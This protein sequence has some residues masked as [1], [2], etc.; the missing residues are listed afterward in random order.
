M[1][2]KSKLKLSAL[3]LSVGMACSVQAAYNPQFSNVYSFGDSLSDMGAMKGTT[4]TIPG[5]EDK[6][7]ITI[8]NIF[9]TPNGQTAAGHIANN[10]GK[11]STAA[12]KVKV[13]NNQILAIALGAMNT[14]TAKG[15]HDFISDGMS[16]SVLSEKAKGEVQSI[17]DQLQAINKLPTSDENTKASNALISEAQRIILGA[18]ITKGGI[19]KYT[20]T[21]GNNFAVGGASSTSVD[22][23]TTFPLEQE[24]EI[25]GTKMMVKA[26]V[27]LM[28]PSLKDQVDRYL[29]RDGKADPNAL[30]T[31]TAGAN[32]LFRAST[33]TELAKAG[34]YNK[35]A[36]KVGSDAFI[37]KNAELKKLVQEKGLALTDKEIFDQATAAGKAAAEQYVTNLVTSVITGSAQEVANQTKR[38]MDAGAKY[39][40]VTNMPDVTDTPDYANKTAAEKAQAKQAVDGF[41][42]MLQASLGQ[43]GVIYTDINGF[44]KTVKANP[45]RY[46]FDTSRT[47]QTFCSGSSLLCQANLTE[48]TR[49][50]ADMT[51]KVKTQQGD[52]AQ[53]QSKAIA[54]AGIK[55]K[56]DGTV[57]G[58]L[59][60]AQ[61]DALKKAGV[62]TEVTLNTKL[63]DAQALALQE[64]SKNYIFADGVHPSSAVHKYLS[65]VVSNG[66][67]KAPGYHASLQSL[68][69]SGQNELAELFEG[70]RSALAANPL[71]KGE[72]RPYVNVSGSK[73]D[74][75]EHRNLAKGNV[76]SM[77]MYAAMDY[78]ISEKTGGGLMLTV[79]RDKQDFK[80]DMAGKQEREA[81]VA[82]AYINQKIT[83][84][85]SW[86]FN[87]YIGK[88]SYEQMR[89]YQLG[90]GVNTNNIVYAE[91]TGDTDSIMAGGS[92]GANGTYTVSGIDLAPRANLNYQFERIRGYAETT[93][94]A[95][96]V[97]YD[98]TDLKR[99]ELALGINISKAF[100]VSGMTMKPYADLDWRQQLGGDKDQVVNWKP[101]ASANGYIKETIAETDR[102]FGTVK[103][104][105]QLVIT[106]GLTTQLSYSKKFGSSLS[107][108]DRIMLDVGYQF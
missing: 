50:G 22:N 61:A 37:A 36:E 63:T 24:I 72:L 106:E 53:T 1:S 35:Q 23:G 30:Y 2:Y 74:G 58:K 99:S 101:T 26:N 91:T 47:S 32:D 3:A 20:D 40:V 48:L 42:Q 27:P 77:R 52:Q 51:V 9:T 31:I 10:Y 15:I 25:F 102:N 95:G 85:W 12:L 98:Q 39:V 49:A 33:V 59:T 87:G 64:A 81:Y 90:D 18:Y 19:I 67:L 46:G 34:A 11:Q 41:N 76:E 55:L 82:G 5:M 78:G 6:L 13:D 108:G 45:E 60:V 89:S 43:R 38:L 14:G 83:Q 62:E 65:D 97:R 16:S 80:K 17:S 21:D 92:L 105:G 73:R 8:S 71:A 84:N 69:R 54:D 57:D 103:L 104:G 44:L 70:R 94:D 93:K 68:A 4:L 28:Q 107:N 75:A 7:S 88:G 29:E 100:T 86:G 96:A 56:T 79:Q 66:Y